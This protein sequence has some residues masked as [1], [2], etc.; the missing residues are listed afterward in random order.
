MVVQIEGLQK[1]MWKA[2]IQCV[3]VWMRG[4]ETQGKTREKERERESLNAQQT[5]THDA[6]W[7]ERF[8]APSHVAWQ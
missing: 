4:E 7:A 2:G 1:N 8:I 5:K 6:R 3:D